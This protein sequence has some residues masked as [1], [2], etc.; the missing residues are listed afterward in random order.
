MVE[1]STFV[2]DEDLRGRNVYICNWRRPSRSKRLH[3]YQFFTATW[4]LNNLPSP[5]CT[6]LL[7]L[8][9]GDA[10]HSCGRVCL[11]ICLSVCA[12]ACVQGCV[13][14]TCSV[15]GMCVCTWMCTCMCVYNCE[16]FTVCGVCDSVLVWTLCVYVCLCHHAKLAVSYVALKDWHGPVYWLCIVWARSTSYMQQPRFVQSCDS[17]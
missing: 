13:R 3:F 9:N 17:A 14:V 15:C 5:R 7:I 8:V 6:Y 11:Y 10:Q 12:S 16:S 4:L 1:T 2:T